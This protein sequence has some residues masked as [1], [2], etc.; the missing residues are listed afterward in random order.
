MAN[1]DEYWDSVYPL[2]SSVCV[3]NPAKPTDMK[4]FYGDDVPTP[5]VKALGAEKIIG[6]DTFVTKNFSA[7]ALDAPYRPTFNE[8]TTFMLNMYD[9]N[10]WWTY[11]YF[12]GFPDNTA[13]E[14]VHHLASGGERA[15]SHNASTTHYPGQGFWVYY[16]PGT[17]VWMNLGKTL[18]SPNKIAAMHTL[19]M[20]FEEIVDKNWNSSQYFPKGGACEAVQ[21]PPTESWSNITAHL[22]PAARNLSPELMLE[23]AAYGNSRLAA[24]HNVSIDDLRMINRLAQIWSA[25]DDVTLRAKGKGY[26]TVQ[27][28]TQPNGCQGWAHEIVFIGGNATIPTWGDFYKVVKKAMLVFDPCDVD[29]RL[30]GAPVDNDLDGRQVCDFP[31]SQYHCAYCSQ[32]IIQAKDCS[33]NTTTVAASRAKK[34]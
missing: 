4:F 32:S 21:F 25:D 9:P 22:S 27:F 30:G 28:T 12:I 5:I 3:T 24:K 14:S 16:G 18:Q 2:A 26:D 29:S 8:N 11:D 6:P 7:P 34:P 20:S 33:T 19:G 10:A 13:V 15:G 23:L 17:G 31:E 1:L